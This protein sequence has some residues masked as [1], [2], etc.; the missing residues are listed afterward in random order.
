M[1]EF[2]FDSHQP[3][4]LSRK[5]CSNV[6]SRDLRET[7]ASVDWTSDDDFKFAQS[8]FICVWSLE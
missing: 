6:I 1:S 8:Q 5:T 4:K 2:Q 3:Q 7:I